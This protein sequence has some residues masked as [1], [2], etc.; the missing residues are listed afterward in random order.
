[1]ELYFCLIKMQF[2]MEIGND[3]EYERYLENW[4]ADDDFSSSAVLGVLEATG[5]NKEDKKAEI[6]IIS[7]QGYIRY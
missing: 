1:M 7:C 6:L 4:I 2:N 5:G 3:Y